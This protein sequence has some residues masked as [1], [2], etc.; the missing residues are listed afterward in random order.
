MSRFINPF[1]DFGFKYL[2]GREVS[3]ELLIEFLNDL[4][5]GEHVIKDLQF[6]KNE[7]LPDYPEG[8]GIIFDI[9]CHT[10]AG[11]YIIVEMQGSQHTN[12]KERSLYYMSRAF[13]NQAIAG[14]EW[15]FNV[16]AVY[17]VFL[18][19]F[20]LDGNSKL[21]IDVIL[22]DR[23]TGELFCDKYRQIFISLPLF[24]KNENECL[25]DF[26]RWIY[27]LKNMETLKR[28]PFKAQKAVFEKLEEIADF[29]AL[30]PEERDKYEQ[31]VK[32]YRDYLVTMDAAE[33]KGLAK[34]H[35]EGLAKGH[36]EGHA[37]GLAEGLAEGKLE[38]K[39]ENA[40][41]L[42]QLGVDTSIIAQATG[43][44]SDEINAL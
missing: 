19:N 14:A 23:D 5:D 9:Y 35:A 11:E 37:E 27:V 7:Q 25:T 36:A 13:V 6:L 39:R 24:D 41:N 33:Q 20:I 43:L 3:K 44:T 26:D 15:K 34:G 28:M 22:A 40:R 21:R 10:A 30:P 16:K 18:M 32:V 2:F 17:G 38:A 42:K 4:L 29:A 12:F 8:R 1:S 31:S